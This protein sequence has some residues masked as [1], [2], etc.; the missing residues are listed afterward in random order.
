MQ[1]I[2]TFT[3]SDYPHIKEIFAM[4]IAAGNATFETVVPEWEFLDK[5]F[6][7]HPRFIALQ[8]TALTGWIAL[9]AVSTRKCYRGV[10][11]VSIYVH[12]AWHNKGV[13]TALLQKAIRASE[14]NGI[15]S[16]LAV[17]H[18]DN[19]ASIHLHEK[20]GF[21]MIGYR[22]RIAQLNGVWKTTVMM[23]RRST[24]L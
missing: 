4:G 19:P 7:P 20:C 5:K 1:N 3:E 17:I 21:R 18:Q 10:A 2:R 15:W 24:V 8:G 13:G 6:L 9:S 23:E 16:L 22:E 12:P 14:E 11:E